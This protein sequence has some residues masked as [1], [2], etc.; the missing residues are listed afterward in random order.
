MSLSPRR[1]IRDP[2]RLISML[3]QPVFR[4]IALIALVLMP[5]TMAAAPTE[6]HAMPQATA[7]DHCGDHS[8]RQSAPAT[9]MAQCMLMC[10]ALPAAEP[11]AVIA[12]DLP[13]APLQ[14]ARIRPFHGIILDIATPPPRPA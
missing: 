14:L 13:K 3:M 10:A 1:L 11:L 2:A 8:D 5:F 6:A 12:P 7:S 4:L 9:D